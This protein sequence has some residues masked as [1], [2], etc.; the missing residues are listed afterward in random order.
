MVVAGRG[1]RNGWSR[2]LGRAKIHR[3]C[4]TKDGGGVVGM[5]GKAARQDPS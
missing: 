2:E 3:L 5:T 1:W 4:V